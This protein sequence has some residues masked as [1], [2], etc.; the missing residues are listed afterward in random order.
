MTVCDSLLKHT[1][2][3]KPSH[4]L[5]NCSVACVSATWFSCSV[6]WWRLA[7][8]SQTHAPEQKDSITRE[9]YQSPAQLLGRQ[10][11]TRRLTDTVTGLTDRQADWNTYRLTHRL[12]DWYT[13]RWTHRPTHILTDWHTDMQTD[14]HTDTHTG[15]LTYIQ[16]E[17]H[18]GRVTDRQT[19]TQTDRMTHSQPW[20][21]Q[22][23]KAERQQREVYLSATGL[24]WLVCWW[25]CNALTERMSA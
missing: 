16:T 18:T 25:Y 5:T 15:R 7:T 23:T 13:D 24:S 6:S 11:Q 22:H 17:T 19:D 14:R 20:M 9:L 10:T 8:I 2:G 12:M 4:S 3:P 1:D 21:H